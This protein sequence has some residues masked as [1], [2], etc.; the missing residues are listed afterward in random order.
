MKSWGN[1]H[2]GTYVNEGRTF[3]TPTADRR[4]VVYQKPPIEEMKN[5]KEE[6]AHK[7]QPKIYFYMNKQTVEE[8]CKDKFPS[9]LDGVQLVDR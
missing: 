4:N 2:C 6:R 3:Q 9:C 7:N 5:G 8:F 1:E